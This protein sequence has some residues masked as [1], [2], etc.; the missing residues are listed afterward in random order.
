MQP[1]D[2][3]TRRRDCISE[4]HEIPN[5]TPVLPMTDVNH[6]TRLSPTLVEAIAGL[7]AGSVATLVVHPLDIVKTRMQSEPQLNTSYTF[8]TISAQKLTTHLVHRSAAAGSQSRATATSTSSLAVLRSLASDPRPVAALYRGLTPNLLGNAASWAGFFYFKAHAERTIAR[9]RRGSGS[10][11]G[12]GSGAGSGFGSGSGSTTTAI[13]KSDLTPADFFVASLSAGLVTQA[14]TNPLWVLKTRMISTSA[15][16]TGAYPSMLAGAR[17]LLRA[18]GPRGFYRGL[19]VSMIGPMHGAVQFAVYE[20]AKRAWLGWRLRRRRRQQQRELEGRGSGSSGSDVV[21]TAAAGGGPHNLD[22][23]QQ[24]QQQQ[25]QLGN[26]ATVVLSTLAKLVA[27]AVTYPYQVV[28]SRVQNHDAEARFG[29]G[30]RGVV[31]QLWREEGWRGFYRGLAPGLV[32]FLPSTWVTFL[33]YENVKL[34]LPGMVLS[35]GA[36]K[37]SMEES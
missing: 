21:R 13:S 10:A 22:R 18:E 30:V 7:S 36:E 2:V 34:Y 32:R 35:G 4:Q 1:D 15:G 6:A 20:P 23:Q 12:S 16:E 11:S 19:A 17:D 9:F 27:N 3:I 37:R 14:L 5:R 28:R 24:Q 33:V 29:V 31:R 8:I 25:E 26:D